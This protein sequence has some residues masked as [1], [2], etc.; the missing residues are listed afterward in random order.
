[1]LAC[2]WTNKTETCCHNKIIIFT[3][4][5]DPKIPGIVLKNDLKYLHKFETL[6]PFEVLPLPLDAAIPAPLPMLETVSKIFNAN[7][8][9][10]R[11]SIA[12]GT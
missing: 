10:G 2:R 5:R 4:G 6:V 11:L 3:W 9:K 8:V 12:G 7:V 1:M